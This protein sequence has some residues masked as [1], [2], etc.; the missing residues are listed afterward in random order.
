MKLWTVI[1]ILLIILTT[2]LTIYFWNKNRLKTKNTIDSF[3][4]YMNNLK[5]YIILT[6]PECNIPYPIYYINMDKD[7]DRKKSIEDQLSR[8]STNHYRIKGF[9]GHMIKSLSHDKLE[10]IEFFNYYDD[11]TSSEIGCVLSHI[12]AIKTAYDNNDQLA[13]ICEDDLIFDTCSINDSITDLILEAPKDWE[14]LQLSNLSEIGQRKTREYKLRTLEH[15]SLIWGTGCYIINNI[16]MEKVISTTYNKNSNT[17]SIIPLFTTNDEKFPKS[18][19]TDTYI[20]DICTTYAIIPAIFV[21]DNNKLNSTIHQDHTRLHIER[22][23]NVLKWNGKIS[24]KQIRFI[25]TLVDIDNILNDSNQTYF[26]SCGTALGV[27]REQK[28]IEHDFDIDLGIFAKDYDKS[29]EDKILSKFTLTHRLGTLDTGYELSFTHPSTKVN[30]DIFLYYPEQDYLWAPSFFG[31]CDKSEKKMCRLK[32]SKFDL[33]PISFLGRK[34]N[35]PH[36][37]ERYLQ[38]SYGLDW[39]VPKIFSYFDGLE[40]G[41]YT[42][43]MLEDFPIAHR[44]KTLTTIN[45]KIPDKKIVWQYWETSPNS[46]QPGYIKYCMDLVRRSCENDKIE[47][48]HLTPNNIDQYIPKTDIPNNWYSIKELAHK[49][50]YIR[51]LVLYHHGGLWIDSDTI[52]R[53]TLY[54]LFD[55][56]NNFDWVVFADKNEEISIGIFAVRQYSFL[57][58]EWIKAMKTLLN[59][60][61]SFNW[62]ELGYDILYPL[63]KK[64]KKQYNN[65]LYKIY[66]LSDTCF[67]ISWDKWETFFKPGNSD[68]IDREFM[69]VTVLYNKMF[70]KWFKEMDIEQFKQFIQSSDTVIA[71]L[72]RKVD[73][74][75]F[76]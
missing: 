62:T 16:G 12:K 13:I 76:K 34:F 40:N 5:E 26:L 75:S 20:L 10:G 35:I 15:N 25:H 51:A 65:W 59:S 64:W 47:Y 27:H 8:V 58:E 36:P 28:F 3:T 33:H 71:D 32:Y 14:I 57:M 19:T 66:D 31:L 21:T 61:N 38:E 60:K 63:W 56:L 23:L 30:V 48:V 41:N 11:M 17:I 72:F 9:N 7:I 6:N 45:G 73:K 69:P 68:F 18:G 42:N 50:D 44:P 29:I 43:L 52:I 74:F 54:P 55:D 37:I 49:A 67:P 46:K 1:T 2:I 24:S 39:K 70:P 4:E 53:Q 22:S